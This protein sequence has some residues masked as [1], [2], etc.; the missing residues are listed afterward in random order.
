MIEMRGGLEA[1]NM[2]HSV[3]HMMAWSDAIMAA[4]S[5]TES[6]FIEYSDYLAR[7]RVYNF[8]PD[9]ATRATAIVSPQ[10]HR[11]PGYDKMSINAILN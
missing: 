8:A 3:L 11:H 5:S 4:E 1:V 7:M 9:E 10:R 6:N 2:P